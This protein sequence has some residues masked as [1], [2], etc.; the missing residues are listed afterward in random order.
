[1][2][3]V[4]PIKDWQVLVQMK[5]YL[6]ERNFRNYLIFRVGV[7]LGLSVQDLLNLKVE[8]L[9]GKKI[10]ISGD[11]QIEISESLQ[12]EIKRHLGGRTSGYLFI[13]AQGNP[14]SRFQLYGILKHTA[15]AVGFSEP[16][17]AITLRKT[18]AYWAY[19]NRQIYL[20]LLSKYLNHHTVQHTLRYMEIK[21]DE[22]SET[23]IFLS[24][25]DL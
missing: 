7:N 24:A 2:G 9:L 19:R 3:V 1:M 20:P 8:D 5:E 13:S 16:I 22:K 21:E 4:S 10:F 12:E 6:R 25:M 11:C 23:D 17:G 15:D 14:L 18:F